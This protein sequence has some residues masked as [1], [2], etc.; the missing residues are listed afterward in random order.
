M[1]EPDNEERRSGEDR[2][3]TTRNFFGFVPR[4]STGDIIT[5]GGLIFTVV[6]G[7]AKFDARIARLEELQRMQVVLDSGQDTRI[8]ELHIDIK[9][10][11]REIK[12]E[13][14]ASR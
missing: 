6:L 3:V 7:W 10:E 5:I 4:I 12:Q 9:N 14:K 13:I 11:L 8:K 1:L 2:R